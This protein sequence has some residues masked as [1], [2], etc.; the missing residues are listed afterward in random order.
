MTVHV[1][2][3][4]G[5]ISGPFTK[6]VEDRKTVETL[7]DNPWILKTYDSN[8]RM[9]GTL[10]TTYE[11]LIITNTALGDEFQVLADWKTKWVN[12]AKVEC[13]SHDTTA[14]ALKE[15][16]RDYHDNHGTQYVLLGG[17]VDVVPYHTV[18]V[19]A[20]EER[21]MIGFPVPNVA[22]DYWFANLH[23]I[24]DAISNYDVYIGRAPVDNDTEAANF[25]RKVISF[26]QMDKP[27]ANLF[28]QSRV[29]STNVPDSLELAR[30]CEQTVPSDYTNYELFAENGTVEKGNWTAF[31]S[32]KGIMFEHIGHGNYTS[33]SIN[34]W[35]DTG[36]I[37]WGNDDVSSLNNTFWPMLTSVACY[38]GAFEQD[39]CLAETLVKDDSGAIACLMNDNKGYGSIDT[40][41]TYSGAFVWSQFYSLYHN[42]IEKIGAVL[43]NSK[44]P[45]IQD[46]T[47]D[48]NRDRCKWELCWREI[49][50]IGDPETPLL[51][52]R[53]SS[54]AVP[55][56]PSGAAF[57]IFSTNY[58]Y[59][60]GTCDPE[61]DG[62]YYEF[63]W[64]DGTNTTVGPIISGDTANATHSWSRPKTYEVRVRAGDVF[65]AWS[66][67]SVSTPVTIRQNDASSG[68]DAGN[69]FGSAL[70]IYPSSFKGNLYVSDPYDMED[71]YRIYARADQRIF[72]SMVPPTGVDFDLELYDPTATLR[73]SSSHG[74]GQ[75]E[76]IT[77]FADMDGYWRIRI[78]IRSGEG[79]YSFTV[80]VRYVGPP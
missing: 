18:T 52:K 75:T 30:Q 46:A 69:G 7:V 32:N 17:D 44:Y 2:L 31:W 34:L 49:N 56:P 42:H 60:T 57:G 59:N 79:E 63:V 53:E 51:T 41:V 76:R 48:N 54:P 33:M 23:G 24:D 67:Y 62:I 6:I 36:K 68:I 70:S 4:P 39:D 47:N 61:G 28:H 65:G 19:N 12:G 11:Y 73:A 72:V 16:I 37:F 43:A 74:E 66:D 3:K 55:S 38:C 50:L 35:D 5:N 29:S 71:W 1:K 15:I 78:F 58:T 21:P 20:S 8:S 9:A 27:K 64:D 10:G 26:E 80:S 14:E 25:V 77:F 45:F 40:V 13:V 22:E